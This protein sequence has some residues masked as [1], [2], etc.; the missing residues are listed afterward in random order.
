LTLFWLRSR[1]TDA[2]VRTAYFG[3]QKVKSRLGPDQEK[4]NPGAQFSP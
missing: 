3:N 4:R 2:A 1:R